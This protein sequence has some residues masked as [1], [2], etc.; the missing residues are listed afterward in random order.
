[1]L[2]AFEKLGKLYVDR[3]MA[4]AWAEQPGCE[5]DKWLSLRL[6]LKMYAFERQGRS[7]NYSFAAIDAID[8]NRSVPLKSSSTKKVWTSFAARLDNTNLNHAN[9][10]LCPQN[11]PYERSY[12]KAE[13]D[14][15]GEK[16]FSG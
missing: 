14:Q 4:P 8:E 7:P 9:N 3:L 15:H 10:P 5:T 11:E 1:M 12:K 13:T 6:F 16:D 2:K